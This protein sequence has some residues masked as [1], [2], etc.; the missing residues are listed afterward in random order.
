LTLP[1]SWSALEDEGITGAIDLAWYARQ[2]SFSDKGVLDVQTIPKQLADI[3]DKTNITPS[4]LAYVCKR[5]AEDAQ[6]LYIWAMY[7][8]FFE[9]ADGSS[10]TDSAS[11]TG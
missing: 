10:A 6:V 3:A 4:S 11:A 9:Y 2:M 1:K 8:S 5:L 7:N